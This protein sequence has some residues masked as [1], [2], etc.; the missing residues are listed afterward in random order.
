MVD[1][2]PPSGARPGGPWAWIR[3]LLI[4]T[5]SGAAYVACAGEGTALAV[6]TAAALMGTLH[7]VLPRSPRP[8]RGDGQ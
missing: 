6:G 2:N 4:V 5:T 1:M 8:P 3:P 7:A